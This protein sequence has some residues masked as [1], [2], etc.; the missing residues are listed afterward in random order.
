MPPSTELASANTRPP[1]IDADSH[2]TEPP[3]VWTSRVS[4]KWGD[5]VPHVRWADAPP[6]DSASGLE[7]MMNQQRELSWFIGDTKIAG[8][9]VSAWAGWSGPFPTHP[10]SYEEAIPASYDAA[11]RLRYLDEAGIQ[12]QALYPNVGGLG[13]QGFLKLKEPELMLECVRAYN[14]FLIDWISPDPARFIPIACTPF[15][16]VEAA[17]KEISRAA[18]RGHKGVV[19][20]G[21]PQSH[22]LPYLSD[23]HWDPIWAAAQESGLPVS[24]H[25]GSGDFDEEFQPDAIESFGLRPYMSRLETQLYL[26]N[27]SQVVDLLLSGI[28]PR[29]PD[30]R[31]VIVESGIG[32]IPFVLEAVDYTF[33]IGDAAADR[34][35]FKMLPSEYFRRQV[36]S[37]YWFERVAPKA[38]LEYI[39]VD[40]ILFETDFPHI[41]CL[42]GKESID[43]HVADGLGGQPESV[44]RQILFENA[45][46]LYGVELPPEQ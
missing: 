15:W 32:W 16:D 37:C 31:F 9:T 44:R 2:V 21:T 35:E 30:L 34:P 20:S 18:E 4:R 3:D 26:D 14:D 39:G 6:P 46:S 45:A 43:Q 40:N 11:A 42:Y 12:A 23:R 27:A 25:I 5:L 17:A 19:L 7:L 13:S 29:F 24:F 8:A 22:G 28:L 10:L 38:L 1:I 41:V 36:Y 33:K